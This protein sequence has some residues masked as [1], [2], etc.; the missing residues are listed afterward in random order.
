MEDS[1]MEISLQTVTKCYND[2]E[3]EMGMGGGL[4]A[5][6]SFWSLQGFLNI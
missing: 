2:F 1:P 6:E 5:L 3:E 4:A